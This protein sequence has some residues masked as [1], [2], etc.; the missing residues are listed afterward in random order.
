[1]KA[2]RKAGYL[3][4]T[5]IQAQVRWYRYPGTGAPVQVS[6]HS[7]ICTSIQSRHRCN[8]TGIQAQVCQ[9]R[10]PGTGASI[11]VSRH[12]CNSTG[13]QAQLRLYKYPIQAQVHWCSYP[14]TGVSI[15]VPR[16]RCVDT[17]I[18]SQGRRRSRFDYLAHIT[19]IPN[20][21]CLYRL[22]ALPDAQPTMSKHWRHWVPNTEPV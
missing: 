12:R 13:I 4:P 2:V 19:L 5:P 3:Q 17:G 14:G 20:R 16:H 7:C 10:Y 6:R 8:S 1:M 18:Q 15:Q 11:Q 9:Y 21:N 22:D